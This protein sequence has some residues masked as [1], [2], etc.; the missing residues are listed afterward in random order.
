[1]SSE[2]FSTDDWMAHLRR[3]DIP[4]LND[5]LLGQAQRGVEY[6]TTRLDMLGLAG[7]KVL[8]AGCGAGN[9]TIPLAKR[10]QS[11]LAVDTDPIRL[12]IVTDMAPRL[13]NVE[14]ALCSTEKIDAPDAEFDCIFCSGVVFITDVEKTISEFARVLKPSGILYMSFVGEEWWR[15]LLTQRGVSEPACIEFGSDGLLSL[16][17]RRL[18]E[19]ELESIVPA[20]LADR[21]SEVVSRHYPGKWPRFRDTPEAVHA[22]LAERSEWDERLVADLLALL[23]E[24]LSMQAGT[25]LVRRRAGDARRALRDLI[26]PEVAGS[27]RKRVA[28]DFVARALVKRRDFQHLVHTYTYEPEDMAMLLMAQGFREIQVASEGVLHVA[29]GVGAAAP[30]Y[31]HEHGV[32]E[33]LARMDGR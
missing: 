16:L 14:T 3:Y 23:D 19:I 29:H 24:T 4:A 2:G 9:W 20:T 5:W 8:D 22:R 28:K 18:N 21:V 1:M 15:F 12:Q 13:G 31:P 30:I 11:V 10:F 26:R 6:W 17:F 27:Y 25:P 32:F 33:T 7:S